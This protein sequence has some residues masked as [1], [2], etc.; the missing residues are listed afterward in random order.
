MSVTKDEAI[1]LLQ[2]MQTLPDDQKAHLKA[3]RE[4]K[5]LGS[6]GHVHV[7]YR[8]PGAQLTPPPSPR[9]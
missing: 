3:L 6:C 8:Q 4:G 9:P 1:A 7:F 2:Y 5:P